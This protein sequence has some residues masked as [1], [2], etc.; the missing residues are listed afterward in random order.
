MFPST[1]ALCS[2]PVSNL[3]FSVFMRENTAEAAK[4]FQCQR[5]YTECSLAY[6]VNG[7]QKSI[8]SFFRKHVQYV[9][10]R[11]QQT[12]RAA[13]ESLEQ[14]PQHGEEPVALHHEWVQMAL[15]ATGE[16]PGLASESSAL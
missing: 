2:E 12:S 11:K 4:R 6:N 9:M 14:S 7:S 16:Q 8:G 5:V 10:A 15:Q 13:L 3:S 1:S